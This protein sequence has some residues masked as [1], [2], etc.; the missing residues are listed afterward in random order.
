MCYNEVKIARLERS[1]I[2]ANNK[3]AYLFIRM[4]VPV[5]GVHE[6]RKKL[7]NRKYDRSISIDKFI[8]II[9]IIIVNR[10]EVARRFIPVGLISGPNAI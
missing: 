9:I 5:P 3:N 4:Q 1:F 8:I 10:C 2:S 7:N 6:K